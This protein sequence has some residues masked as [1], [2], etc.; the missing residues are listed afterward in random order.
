MFEYQGKKYIKLNVSAKK[1]GADGV[2]KT[3]YVLSI[4]GSLRPSRRASEGV[5]RSNG[6]SSISW[7]SLSPFLFLS[8]RC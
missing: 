5:F 1:N 7:G 4:L 2:A 6:G 8:M 3:H